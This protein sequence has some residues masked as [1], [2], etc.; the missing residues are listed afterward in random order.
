[1]AAETESLNCNVCL[2]Q[3]DTL[4]CKK[5]TFLSCSECIIKWY[6]SQDENK[7]PQCKKIDTFDI[8]Y[9]E[10]K[11]ENNVE[12]FYIMLP[13]IDLMISNLSL[14]GL[15][16]EIANSFRDGQIFF[17]ENFIENFN[18]WPESIKQRFRYHPIRQTIDDQDEIVGYRIEEN[19]EYE[20]D[21]EYTE[22]EAEDVD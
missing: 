2:K 22:D 17:P 20:S 16:E 10:I 4:K 21:S 19:E 18:N 9:E 11:R 5:C 14:F 13:L 15:G 6:N 3:L 7:C 8:N 1:M 12:Q